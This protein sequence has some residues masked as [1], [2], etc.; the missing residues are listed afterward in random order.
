MTVLAA[1]PRYREIPKAVREHFAKKLGCKIGRHT[2]LKGCVATAYC[3][4]CGK[5]GKILNN[6]FG[7]ITLEDLNFDHIIPWRVG[8]TNEISNFQILC[9]SCNHKKRYEDR[10]TWKVLYSKKLSGKFRLYS[11]SKG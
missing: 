4:H 6:G 3:N 10:K 8:G 9:P 11:I 1:R 2:A 5:R 7:Y